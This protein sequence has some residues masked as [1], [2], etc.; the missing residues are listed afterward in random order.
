MQPGSYHGT[1]CTLSAA[2]AAGLAKGEPLESAVSG[3]I[4]FVQECMQLCHSPKRGG[5][6]LLGLPQLVAR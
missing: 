6:R 5:I 3:A 2:I 4:E 1:G